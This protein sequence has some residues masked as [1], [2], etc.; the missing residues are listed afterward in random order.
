MFAE[1]DI[2]WQ[3]MFSNYQKALSLLDKFVEKR[4]DLSDLEEQGLIKSF[5]YTYELGWN[6]LKDYLT[7]QGHKDLTGSRDAIQKAFQIE[8]ITDGEAW[9]DMFQSR[10]KTS[11]TYN[12]KTAHEVKEAILKQ[13]H[14]LFKQ[15]ETRFIG[16]INK[17]KIS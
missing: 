3:R 16:L 5:E 6:T 15:L 13:Y 10:N 11:H 8:L 7:F 9:M 1:Q 4:A 17:Q 12:E 14:T 2:R